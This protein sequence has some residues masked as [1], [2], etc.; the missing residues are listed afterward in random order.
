MKIN[1]LLLSV[2]LIL[3]LSATA[4]AE[5]K[6]SS[7]GEEFRNT[8]MEYDKEA[9]KQK[10]AGNSAVASR[11]EKLAAIKRNAAN[12]ADQNKWQEIDW[13]EYHKINEEIASLQGHKGKK[14]K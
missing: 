10:E 14:H 5:G 11:Y 6:P 4:I 8:A 13:T 7:G 3:T 9:I 12:L 2:I 1:N